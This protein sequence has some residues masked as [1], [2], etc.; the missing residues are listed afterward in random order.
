MTTPVGNEQITLILGE[1]RF[2]ALT[3]ADQ[4]MLQ[5]H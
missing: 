4:M 2:L 1:A 3:Q 5:A